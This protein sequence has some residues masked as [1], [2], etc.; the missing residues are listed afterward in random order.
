MIFYKNL[1]ISSYMPI[2]MLFIILG[3]AVLYLLR[4]LKT[5]LFSAPKLYILTTTILYALIL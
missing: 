2:F 5:S 4:Y 3:Y 1:N